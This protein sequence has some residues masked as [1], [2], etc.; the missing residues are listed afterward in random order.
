MSININNNASQIPTL[1]EAAGGVV[2]PDGRISASK[3]TVITEH[4]I[5]ISVNGMPVARLNCTPADLTELVLGRLYT[6]RIIDSSDDVKKLFICGQGDIAEVELE[7]GIELEE[8]VVTEPT[9]CTAN[10]Q[11]LVKKNGRRLS[12]LNAGVTGVAITSD[13][14][15]GNRATPSDGDDPAE[16]STIGSNEFNFAVFSMAEY[17]R[18]DSRLHKS[19][20]GTHSCYLRSPE[21]EIRGFEDV[22]RHNALDKAVGYMLLQKLDPYRC[23]LFTSGRIASDMAQKAIAS[24]IPV[25]ISKAVP[26][27]EALRLARE[28]GLTLIA[29]AWPDSYTLFN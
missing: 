8:S 20:G 25:L 23:M 2:T 7:S 21:G 6:E 10:R 28:Y 29:K 15:I 16:A 27:D 3:E 17:F 1:T 19:T 24:G 12:Q 4:T 9:C 13:F 11:L 18:N 26:T 5:E 22:S 14:C